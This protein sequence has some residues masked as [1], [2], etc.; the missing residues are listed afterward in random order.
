MYVETKIEM[1]IAKAIYSEF[2]IL[3]LL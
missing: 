3:S 1:P 2:T